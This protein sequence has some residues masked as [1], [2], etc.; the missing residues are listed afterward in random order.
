MLNSYIN[1]INGY[2]YCMEVTNSFLY[3]TVKRNRTAYSEWRLKNR[4]LELVTVC[5]D[6]FRH[7][8]LETCQKTRGKSLKSEI[9]WRILAHSKLPKQ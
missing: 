7:I 8:P 3:V 4:S 9:N 6:V 5:Y 2:M 1:L